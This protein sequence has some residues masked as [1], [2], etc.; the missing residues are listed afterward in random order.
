MSRKDRKPQPLQ[1]MEQQ[2]VADGPSVPRDASGREIKPYRF[3]PL[4]WSG[5][6]GYGTAYSTHEQITY[7]RCDKSHKHDGFP[8]GHTWSVNSITEVI[9]TKSRFVD[10]K[11]ASVGPLSKR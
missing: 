9:H 8:C 2:S 4:C 6:G 5:R 1:S 10:L 7:Y 3:C 11:S